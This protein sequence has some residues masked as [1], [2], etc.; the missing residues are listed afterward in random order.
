M[1]NQNNKKNKNKENKYDILIVLCPGEPTD[2]CQF[3]EIEYNKIYDSKVYIGGEVRMKSAVKLSKNTNWIILVGGSEK[4]VSCMKKYILERVDFIE[5]KR[6]KNR[7]IRIESDP[8]TNG[9]MHAIR[10]ALGESKKYKDK[11]WFL[12]NSY[13]VKRT[14]LFAKE[15]LD[16]DFDENRF[17]E[18]EDLVNENK[19]NLHYS[20]LTSKKSLRKKLEE[21]GCLD[22]RDRIYRNQHNEPENFKCVLHDASSY[23]ELMGI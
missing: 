10:K 16:F 2:S 9:N 5:K 17:L 23:K 8:D 22:W 21:R 4:K 19:E 14:K 18:A 13:H 15:I 11:L 3:L 1:E 6:L 7:I 12:T 20:C